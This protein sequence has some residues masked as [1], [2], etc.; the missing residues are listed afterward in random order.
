[1]R[2]VRP[3]DPQDLHGFELAEPQRRDFPACWRWQDAARLLAHQGRAFT[4]RDHDGRV[5]L[6]AGVAKVDE[7]YGY[8]WAFTAAHSGPA[9]RWLT[10]KVRGYLD[11]LQPTHRRIELQARADFPQA[12]KWAR[13]L[14]FEEEGPVRC[15]AADSGDMVRFARINRHWTR[16]Q[17]ELAA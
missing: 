14:G 3:F 11:T 15:A 5:L 17:M 9:M 10:R 7:S 16:P 1:M 12:R 8:A 4:L 2:T 6:I 13:L